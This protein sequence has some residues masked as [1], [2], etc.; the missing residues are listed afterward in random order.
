MKFRIDLKIFVFIILFFL[1]K[2]IEIYAIVMFFAFIHELG[3]LIAG[4]MLGMKPEKIEIKPVGFSISFRLKPEDYNKRVKKANQLEVKKIIIALAGP[5]TNAIVILISINLKINILK[6]LT[7]IYANILILLFNILPI[8]PLD[9]GRICKGILHMYFGKEKTYQYINNIS[10]IT[11]SILT[12]IS[13]FA[14]LYINNIAIFII[15]MYLWFLAINENKKYRL[16][17]KIY[18]TIQETY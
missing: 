17:K 13:S 16:K 10:L 7:I 12:I 14:I 2:Q 4:I 8:Y 1:T 18:S 5:M 3:H 15:M 11:V 6:E 9:G